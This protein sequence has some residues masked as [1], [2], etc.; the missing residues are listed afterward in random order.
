[1]PWEK[2][3]EGDHGGNKLAD[4]WEQVPPLTP[5]Q[6]RNA[7]ASNNV[8]EAVAN[9]NGCGVALPVHDHLADDDRRNQEGSGGNCKGFKHTLM[10]A[11]ANYVCTLN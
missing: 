9:A 3:Y 5:N 10:F 6:V 4:D 11:A 8:E 7:A 2:Y 1:M